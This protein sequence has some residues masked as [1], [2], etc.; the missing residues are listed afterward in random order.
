MLDDTRGL[1]VVLVDV[2]VGNAMGANMV[3][4][5]AESLAPE[6]AKLLGGSFGLRILTNLSLKRLVTVSTTIAMEAIGEK[7]ADAIALASDFAELDPMRAV[8]HNKGIMNG[9]DSAA[10]A[11]GQDFRAL[12]AGAHGYASLSGQ[13][14]PLAT[15]KL[16][17]QGI[18]GTIKMPLAVG[19]VGGSTKSHP[20][21]RAAFEVLDVGS[22]KELAIVMASVGLAS[23]FAAL[24]ALASE[25]IQK[26]HMRL[27]NRKLENQATATKKRA[28]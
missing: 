16:V 25:G 2:D 11:L 4:R 10:L 26:G 8:T 9:I 23:N 18:E 24:K 6:L 7:L 1:S 3:D 19:T 14:K 20:G 28:P 12:E 17:S 27:H 22:A 21:V 5:V 13:Y 15:W